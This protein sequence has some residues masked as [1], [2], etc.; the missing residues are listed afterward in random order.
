MHHGALPLA[1]TPTGVHGQ[2]VCGPA[3]NSGSNQND[4]TCT[5]GD[6]F[7]TFVI[8]G[9]QPPVVSVP[10]RV[11]ATPGVPVNLAVAARD[12]TATS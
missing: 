10:A 5:L 7:N 11:A 3:G 12:P 9:D 4:V 8:G 1:F 2:M 6:V